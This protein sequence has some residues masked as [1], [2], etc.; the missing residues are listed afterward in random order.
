MI[1]GNKNI[2]VS[3]KEIRGVSEMLKAATVKVTEITLMLLTLKRTKVLMNKF[4]SCVFL[5][6]PINCHILIA[7]GQCN[8]WNVIMMIV[9]SG[10]FGP[11]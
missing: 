9:N 8:H 7:R 4:E 11:F 5:W 6:H 3:E 1:P 10:T 2:V